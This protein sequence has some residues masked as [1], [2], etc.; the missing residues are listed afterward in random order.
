[1]STHPESRFGANHC[2]LYVII[3]GLIG[4]LLL[5]PHV[6]GRASARTYTRVFVAG[7]EGLAELD[8]LDHLTMDYEQL[9]KDTTPAAWQERRDQIRAERALIVDRHLERLRALLSALVLAV[10]AV[11]VMEA[12][13]QTLGRLTAARYALLAMWITITLAQPMLLRD[14]SALFVLMLIT[15]AL[16]ASHIRLG[17]RPVP[18]ANP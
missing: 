14:T 5:G 6:L 18:T 13:P 2:E 3:V 7:G 4:G 15:M 8:K 17:R 9:F 11:M 16:F 10:V 12:L 1:M